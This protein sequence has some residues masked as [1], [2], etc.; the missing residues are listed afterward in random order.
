MRPCGHAAARSACAACRV[1]GTLSGGGGGCGGGCGGGGDDGGGGGSSS[2]EQLLL[3]RA[4]RRSFRRWPRPP[5]TRRSLARSRVLTWRHEL[6][7][8][9]ANECRLPSERPTITASRPPA[10]RPIGCRRRH[11]RQSR[12]EDG[13]PLG[14]SPRSNLFA[15]LFCVLVAIALTKTLLACRR[16][17]R[18]TQQKS[19]TRNVRRASSVR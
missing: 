4:G 5:H 19:R 12:L 11:F 1:I 14:G 15:R 17:L 2:S 6:Q 16:S 7:H 18:L 13:A 3:E 8:E 10:G 9:R